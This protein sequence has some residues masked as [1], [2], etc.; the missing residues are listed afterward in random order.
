MLPLH[1]G[2]DEF[3][4]LPRIVH[5]YHQ[6]GSTPR[7]SLSTRIGSPFIRASS[8]RL[9]Y[10]ENVIREPRHQSRGTF[11]A[12]DNSHEIHLI[13]LSIMAA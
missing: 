2:R 4:T 8:C 1:T 10:L 11:Q 9:Q 6:L 7:I 3:N 13:F 5:Q 12:I